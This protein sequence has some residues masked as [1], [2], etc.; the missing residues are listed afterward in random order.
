MMFFILTKFCGITSEG[1]N[2]IEDMI[3]ILKTTKG[4]NYVKTAGGVMFFALTDD[5]FYTLTFMKITSTVLNL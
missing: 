5:D 4:H 3:A 2:V 1:F